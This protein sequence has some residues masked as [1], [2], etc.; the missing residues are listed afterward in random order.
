MEDQ[1]QGQKDERLPARAKVLVV[2]DSNVVRAVVAGCL[3]GAGF[4]VGEARSGV[5]ALELL[6]TTAYDVVI[7]DLNMPEMGG[8]AMIARMREQHI[9]GPEVIV[10]TGSRAED[11]QSA[12]EALRLGAHDYLAK[13]PSSPKTIVGAV[14]K[15]LEKKRL[16]EENASLLR[17]LNALSLTDS[18]T[19]VPNR[20]AFDAALDRE[21]A[22]ARRHHRSL[23][24]LMFDIDHFKKVNDV[25]GHQAGDQA[26]RHFAATVSG[27]LRKGD[28]LYRL[29]GEEFVALLPETS[30]IGALEAAARIL[31]GV[32]QSPVVDGG[33]RFGITSSAGVACTEGQE[34]A[35]AL[36]AEAD[37]ALYAAKRGG[38][39]RAFLPTTA[40]HADLKAAC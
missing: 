20:R 5:A 17:Q 30:A 11:V 1:K 33:L 24:L 2:D 3:K 23:A 21:T 40:L 28:S 8:L 19:G 31:Q 10:L 6:G 22:R 36:L 9:G 7:T 35:E 16:R 13:P 18:L 14:E 15:A 34:S 37:A 12:I 32:A 27:L 39:N 29:G 38:R 26:L 4:E 25:H